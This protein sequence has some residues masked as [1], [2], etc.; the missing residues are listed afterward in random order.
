MENRFTFR[1][2]SEFKDT[3]GIFP[4]DD[5]TTVCETR[6]QPPRNVH[7][8]TDKEYAYPDANNSEGTNIGR[9]TVCTPFRYRSTADALTW[10]LVTEKDQE[11]KFLP[12]APDEDDKSTDNESQGPI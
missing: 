5:T 12:P 10:R 8:F 1:I 6:L 3:T 9:R 7:N 11:T 2:F 4:E